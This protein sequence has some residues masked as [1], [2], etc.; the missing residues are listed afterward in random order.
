M[1][2]V[3]AETMALAN[4]AC[5]PCREGAPTLSEQELASLMGE[6]PGWE[7]IDHHH[8]RKGWRFADFRAALDWV[9]RAGAICEEQGHH[10]EFRLGWGHAEALIHTHKVDGL[11]RADAVLAAR[12]E[13][14]EPRRPYASFVTDR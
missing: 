3:A 11:T 4:E 6:L 13:A 10:A 1:G 9:N 7:V 14:M 5:L 8:L 2:V 12:F